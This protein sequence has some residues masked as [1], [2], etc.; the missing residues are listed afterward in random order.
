MERDGRYLSESMNILYHHRTQGKG[1]E[2]VHIMGIVNSLRQLGNSVEILCLP[3]TNP[4]ESLDRVHNNKI[5]RK[6]FFAKFYARFSGSCPRAVFDL[7]GFLYNLF[8]YLKL[9]GKND[10]PDLIFERYSFFSFAATCYAK[11]KGIPI[12]LEVN[13]LID[14]DSVREIKLKSLGRFIEK[15]VLKNVS[16]IIT[17]SGFNKQCLINE[18]VCSS[19]ITVL[20]NAFD[21][22]IFDPSKIERNSGGGGVGF[23][24]TNEI[25]IGFVGLFVPWHGLDFLCRAF[26]DLIDIHNNIRLLLV[27]DGPVKDDIVEFA[28][29]NGFLDKIAITGFVAHSDVPLYISAMDIAV[30]PD[31]NTHG[32]PMKIF[33][34]MAM[35]IP[36]VAPRYGPI[37]EIISDGET[38][39]LFEPQN[40]K[41]FKKSLNKLIGD[42]KLRREIGAFG[43]DFVWANHTWL[44]NGR[45]ITKLYS[46]IKVGSLAT[47][48]F[49]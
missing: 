34:Y 42:Y 5:S 8:T 41:S 31:S 39:V 9:I 1:V 10:V 20:P 30:M 33:E 4:E 46:D 45:R 11:Q 16:H 17:V 23:S 47:T 36:V 19:K 7:L 37:V 27:G 6:S 22:E 32:S 40:I 21:T 15:R 24:T 14:L 48:G 13:N 49:N 28:R 25:V 43:M 44:D 3:G 18:G 12:F 38:G 2:G 26:F 29:V 35:G